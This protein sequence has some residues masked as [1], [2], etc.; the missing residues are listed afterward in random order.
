MNHFGASFEDR[1]ALA[2]KKKLA[3]HCYY[4]IHIHIHNKTKHL[5][6][7]CKH[8]QCFELFFN[9]SNNLLFVSGIFKQ[10]KEMYQIRHSSGTCVCPPALSKMLVVARVAELGKQVN[11]EE[12]RFETP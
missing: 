11:R 2:G 9:I 6:C 4:L 1:E 10:Q 8:T 7:F 3:S 12:T 5:L